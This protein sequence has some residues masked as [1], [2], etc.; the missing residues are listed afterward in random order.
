MK[1]FKLT[2]LIGVF[3]LVLADIGWRVRIWHSEAPYRA[4]FKFDSL[5]TNSADIFVIRDARTDKTLLMTF[6]T[7]DGEKPGEVSYFMEGTNVLNIYLKKDEPPRYRFIFQDIPG[8]SW[9]PKRRHLA[10]T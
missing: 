3:L 10:E 9:L 7:A 8:I 2:L 4:H 6:D 1:T 5:Y